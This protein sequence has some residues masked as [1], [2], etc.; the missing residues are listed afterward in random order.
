MAMPELDLPRRIAYGR[1]II[2]PDDIATKAMQ[3]SCLSVVS[4][5]RADE[6]GWDAVGAR[7]LSAD[8]REAWGTEVVS[9]FAETRPNSLQAFS[10]FEPR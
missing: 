1:E 4:Y 7:E 6:S 2:L 10:S 9:A 3:G 8:I 5:V